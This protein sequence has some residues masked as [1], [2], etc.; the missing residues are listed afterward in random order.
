MLLDCSEF[1][2]VGNNAQSFSDAV[3]GKA[4][5][6][7]LKRSAAYYRFSLWAL[8]NDVFRPMAPTERTVYEYINWMRSSGAA[9]SSGESF[10]EAV[11]FLGHHFGFA[12]MLAA[13]ML[14]G[15]V[16]M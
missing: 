15:R 11:R 14:T 8:K 10:V 6:T 4:V 13:D 16:F 5:S 12:P 1:L 2:G 9:P 7:L 3:A